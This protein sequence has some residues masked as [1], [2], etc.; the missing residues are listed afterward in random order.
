MNS[1]LLRNKSSPTLTTLT[2]QA[3][4]DFFAEKVTKVRAITSTCPPAIFSGPC[5]VCFD[6]FR[7]CTI[8]EIRQVMLQSPRKSCQFDPLLHT[9]LM[10]SL[11]HVL[12]FIHMLCNKSLQSGILPDSENS[13]AVTPILK[14]PG[15]DLDSS[16]SYRPVSNLTY[17]SK[18]IERHASSQLTAYLLNYHLLPV[19]Q[20]AYRQHYSTETATLKIASD[21]FDAADAEKVTVLSF[22]DLSAAFDTVDYSTLQRLTYTY[23]ITGTAL[24]FLTERSVIVNFQGHQS[25]RSS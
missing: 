17:V 1:V 6:E 11:D 10:V 12:P 13:A 9:L 21:I 18:L 3:L 25:T 24:S 15:L 22:L 23:G 4:A 8:A 19:E 14:K 2:A 7:S 20:S 5:T 16:S